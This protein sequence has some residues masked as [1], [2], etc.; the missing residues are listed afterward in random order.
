MGLSFLRG[1]KNAHRKG[2]ALARVFAAEAFVL[3][4]VAAGIDVGLA[5][6]EVRQAKQETDSDEQ[7]EEEWGESEGGH[8]M[9]LW[10][11]ETKKPP[12]TE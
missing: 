4:N 7:A 9:L 5:E 12:S 8:G 6:D 2:W 10:V 1:N 3:G 11:G